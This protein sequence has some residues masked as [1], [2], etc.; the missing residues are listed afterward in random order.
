M[1]SRIH[2]S[3]KITTAA[4]HF[5]AVTEHYPVVIVTGNAQRPAL[6]T[7]DHL[8]EAMHIADAH[9]ELMPDTRSLWR[10]VVL[11]WTSP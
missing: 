8:R 6:L 1:K 10:R 7:R 9:P 4:R 5:G 2:V 11:W 3:E